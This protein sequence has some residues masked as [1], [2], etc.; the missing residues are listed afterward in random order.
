MNGS[1]RDR[2]PE[3][4]PTVEEDGP[5]RRRGGVISRAPRWVDD[6]LGMSKFAESALDKVFPDHWSFMFGEL[7]F[8]A[9]LLLLGT[10]VYLTFFF[11]PSERAVVYHGTYVPLRGVQM[12]EAYKSVI[13]ISFKVKA[14]MVMRQMHHWAALIFLG[15]IVVH[16]CR[17]FFTGAFRR[18]REI[19]WV[20][21][22]SLLVLGIVNGFAGY[23][24][25]DDLLSGTGLRIAN[26]IILSIPFL[27]P[28]LGSLLFGGEFPAASILS[29]LYIIHVL[30]VPAAI[31]ALL[32][33]HLAIL[34]RQKHT[35]FPGRDK[36]EDTITGSRMWPT[37]GMKSTGLLFAVSAFTAL[38]GGLAQI[39]PIWLYGP[40]KP[41]AVS[42]GSQPDWYM[43][44][45]DGA[46]RMFPNVEIRVFHVTIS[47]L[48]FPAV[49]LPG[50]TFTMLAV[51]P[52]LE[53]RLTHDHEP[54]NLLDRPRDRPVRSA[55][56]SATLAF[57]SI[58]LLG[59]ATDILAT[60]F[61]LSFNTIIRMLQVAIFTVPV[62]V[63][64]V[65]RRICRDLS[66]GRVRPIRQPG[67]AV[68][69]RDAEGRMVVEHVDEPDSLADDDNV[70]ADPVRPN[71]DIRIRTGG[72]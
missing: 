21:G 33:A 29:R 5:S 53:A 69:G 39:N 44:W 22:V 61:H 4:G 58:L 36:S 8:Y 51:W 62:I 15:A 60:T 66:A 67:S 50:I 57:Y 6:R 31:A 70:G 27:G 12:S 28:W 52:W 68:I 56:G 11:A 26:A 42:A 14:G 47:N 45:L 23:S 43:G 18:P 41:A 20:I 3:V 64:L 34:W 24:L 37:Y 65:V 38:L 35:D 25:P 32:T 7:A 10:G 71:K 54:H 17:V 19:N 1:G 48:F 63:F 40:Y 30:L 59:S 55:L 46:L 2:R 13:E 49:V 9:F 72:D 16:L